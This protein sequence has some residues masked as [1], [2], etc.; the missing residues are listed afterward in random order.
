[1]EAVRVVAV[2]HD[3]AQGYVLTQYFFDQL[4]AFEKG[5][6][7]MRD[8]IG[9]MVYGMDIDQQV[10]RARQ[11]EFDKQADGDVL[12]RSKPRVLTG[13]DLAESKLAQGDVATASALAHTALADQSDTLDS[14]AQ[15]A[16]AN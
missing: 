8:T 16:R 3:M 7:S 13:L 11:T 2:H 1:M 12:Q 14:V 15:E 10:H 6:A 9:E 4:I 5:P